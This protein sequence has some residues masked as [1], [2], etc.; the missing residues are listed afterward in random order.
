[1]ALYVEVWKMLAKPSSSRF[2]GNIV[3]CDSSSAM[4]TGDTSGETELKWFED[5]TSSEFGVCRSTSKKDLIDVVMQD[6][7]EAVQISATERSGNLL[8]ECVANCVR[9]TESLS[10]YDFDFTFVG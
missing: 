2:D 10:F 7:A 4:L 8:C 6:D 3:N 5:F 1:V 9:M